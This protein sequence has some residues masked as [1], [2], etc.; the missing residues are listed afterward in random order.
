MVRNLAE[1][2]ASPCTRVG[3][4]APEAEWS[5]M[6]EGLL[7]REEPTSRLLGGTP[8]GRRVLG[9]ALESA[10]HPRRLY[11]TLGRTEVK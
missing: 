2:A 7:L 3:R 9:V 1:G 11:T 6:A 10:G 8:S 4:S 5:T